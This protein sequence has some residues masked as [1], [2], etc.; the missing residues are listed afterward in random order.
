VIGGRA[1]V[2]R[3]GMGLVPVVLR[4]KDIDCVGWWIGVDSNAV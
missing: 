3:K 2:D 4:W 1:G